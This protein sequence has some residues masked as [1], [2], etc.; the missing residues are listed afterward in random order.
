[1][2]D[3]MELGPALLMA[4]GS[5][6]CLSLVFKAWRRQER[7]KRERSSEE[8]LPRKEERFYRMAIIGA[9]GVAILTLTSVVGWALG[10][11]FMRSPHPRAFFLGADTVCCVLM[12]LIVCRRRRSSPVAEDEEQKDEVSGAEKQVEVLVCDEKR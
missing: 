7:A 11:W 9:C 4:V 3:V 1:M 6:L 10:T 5:V 2:L 8:G 12:V